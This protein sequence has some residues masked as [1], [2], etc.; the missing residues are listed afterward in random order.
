MNKSSNI[1]NHIVIETNTSKKDGQQVCPNCGASEITFNE[2]K[3]KL[4]CNYCA[5][6]FDG[7]KLNNVITNLDKLDGTVIGS[8]ARNI[9]T[10]IY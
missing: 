9:K 1:E 3:R 5:T 4:Y 10:D 6:E 8:G 7:K 2:K